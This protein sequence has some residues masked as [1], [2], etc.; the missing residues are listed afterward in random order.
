MRWVCILFPQLALD[1]VLRQRPDP[2]EPLVLLSG[3][4]Q[5][6]VLQAVNPAAR[7]LG[8][9]PGM[10]MTAAQAMSKGFATADYEVAEVEHWQRFLAAW[11]YRFS[12]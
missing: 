11:A 1:A 3:P 6:R 12:A 5:R 2:E 10:S 8:L 9:R 7:K 4:A